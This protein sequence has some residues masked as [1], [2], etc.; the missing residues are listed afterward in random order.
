MGSISGL[1]GFKLLFGGVEEAAAGNEETG[2]GNEAVGDNW[3]SLRTCHEL[4]RFNGLL[5]HVF[6]HTEGGAG[7]PEDLG[8]MIGPPLFQYRIHGNT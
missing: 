7:E 8:S 6:E 2:D 5:V 1:L 3:A 4:N